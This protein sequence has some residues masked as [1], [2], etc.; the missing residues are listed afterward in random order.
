MFAHTATTTP[1]ESRARAHTAA[2]LREKA[3]TVFSRFSPRCINA[4]WASTRR[5]VLQRLA[6]LVSANEKSL[7]KLLS[8]EGRRPIA[9][10]EWEVRRAVQTIQKTEDA[11]VRLAEARSL[12]FSD[13]LLGGHT[14]MAQRFTS[15]P[16]FAI[17]PFNFPLNLSLH[18]IAPAVALGLPFVCKGPAQNFRTMEACAALLEDA[19]VAPED[20]LILQAQGDET[21]SLIESVPFPIISFTGSHTVGLKL[22]QRFWDRKV[23]LELGST[24]AAVLCDDVPRWELERISQVLARSAFGQGGQSCI[25]L[26]H[27]VLEHENSGDFVSYLKDAA[28]KLAEHSSPSDPETVCGPLVNAAA[29]AKVRALLDDARAHGATVWTAGEADD[30]ENYLPPTLVLLAPGRPKKS[31]RL[32][33]EE[34]FGPVVCVQTLAP[35]SGPAALQAA[36]AAETIVQALGAFDANIHASLYSYDSAKVK[37]LFARSVCHSLLWNE[38]PSWRADAMP[39]GGVLGASAD[40]VA[41]G[42]T[43]PVGPHAG[44]VGNEGPLYSLLEYTWE[45]LL[46]LP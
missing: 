6:Q 5:P 14:A 36:A 23:I 11:L 25:S 30:A 45:R 2:Q 12:D 13:A 3:L 43:V 4:Q 31:L 22:K 28:R 41:E 32:L 42:A 46:V 24:A 29:V 10:C 20:F 33:R 21:E 9:S 39:Y 35:G 19:G 40:S 17:A 44:L 16:L 1:A 15:G 38:A 18:K 26:Q 37:S 34:V 27:L 7:A 8:E